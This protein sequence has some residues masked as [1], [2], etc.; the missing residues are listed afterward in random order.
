MKLSKQQI[1]AITNKIEQHVTKL[2]EAEVEARRKLQEAGAK[3]Y[4][5][6]LAPVKKHLEDFDAV[7]CNLAKQDSRYAFD[8]YGSRHRSR[9]TA[10]QFVDNMILSDCADLNKALDEFISKLKV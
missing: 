5:K 2:A 10:R 3:E 6:L 7:V 9:E 8:Y 1:A 4:A